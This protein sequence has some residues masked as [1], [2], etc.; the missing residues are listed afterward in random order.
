LVRKV[1]GQYVRAFFANFLLLDEYPIVPSFQD[2]QFPHHR[3]PDSWTDTL[4]SDDRTTS[5]CGITNVSYAIKRAHLIPKEEEDWFANNGMVRY[6]AEKNIDDEANILPLRKDLHK[7]FDDKWFAFVPD[8]VE[9][10]SEEA[11]S[12]YVSCILSM[13]AAQLWPTYHNIIVRHL[14]PRS[15]PPLFARFAWAVLLKVKP[16]VTSGPARKVIRLSFNDK[17]EAEYNIERLTTTELRRLYGGGGRRSVSAR[18]KK[19]KRG[20]DDTTQDES[21][22]PSSDDDNDIDLDE[23]GPWSETESGDGNNDI[24]SD[25][26]LE[27]KGKVGVENRFSDDMLRMIST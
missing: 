27:P 16:F 18:G 22:F 12:P 11:A 1:A 15:R 20:T 10:G 7:C 9:T 26:K 25:I 2:W 8:I 6:G 17:G 14:H 19:R 24:I 3:I 21:A 4:G 13:P 23:D 5:R